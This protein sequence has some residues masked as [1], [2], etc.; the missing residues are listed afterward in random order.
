MQ[1]A[2]YTKAV[3]FSCGNA[4]QALI[5]AGVD[6]LHIGAKGALTPNH[7]FKQN[8]IARTFPGYFDATSGHLPMELML[9]I[10]AAFKSHLKDSLEDVVYVPSGSGETLVCLQLAY[11]EKKFVAVYNLDNATEYDD[12]APLNRLVD[13]L[14]FDIY[15]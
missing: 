9:A 6:T 1:R 12:N 11:P 13:I 15:K 8:E 4:A 14:A 7:W 10:A 3:C 2:G 5:D